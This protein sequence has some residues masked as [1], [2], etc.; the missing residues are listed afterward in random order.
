MPIR[1]PW[2]RRA[3]A[4]AGGWR[5]AILGATALL[6][7]SHVAHAGTTGKVAGLVDDRQKRPVVAATVA[8]VNQPFGAFTT[9]QGEYSILNVPPGTYELKFSRVGFKALV[10][11]N[12]VVSADNTTRIDATLDEAAITAETVVVTAERPPVDINLTSS[13]ASLRSEDIATLP[14][15]E[16]Q[17]VVNL[18]AGVVDGHFRGGRLGEVQYQVDGVSVNNAYDN[19]SS[20]RVDRS[21]LQEVQVISGTFDAEYGQA[22]SGVVNA[23]LKTGG[24]KLAWESEV[25]LGDHYFPGRESARLT[26]NTFD[27]LAITSFTFTLSGPTGLPKTVFLA[28]A[29]YFTWDDYI[30]AERR[31]LITPVYDD[32][33]KRFVPIPGDR[34]QRVLGWADEWSGALKITNSS[35]TNAKLSYQ[36]L[37]NDSDGQRTN[38][39]YRYLPDGMS[40]QHTASIAHGL[41]WTQ[42]LGKS[43][44]LSASVRQNYRKYQDF[45]YEDAWDPRYD[46][47]MPP[48]EPVSDPGYYWW[49]VDF[50]RFE[51]ITN[52]YLVKA[53]L[54]SQLSQVQQLKAGA[55]LQWPEVTFGV[56]THLVYTGLSVE[57]HDDEPLNGYPAVQ[58][59][60]PLSGAAF[61][62]DQIEWRDLTLR[63]GARLDYFDARASLPSDPAN[64]ANAIASAPQSVPQPTTPKLTLSPR[65]GVAFPV[66]DRSGMHFAYGH[67]YQYPPLGDIFANADYSILSRL[68][69]GTAAFNTVMGN[70]DVKPEMSVQYEFGYKQSLTDDFGVEFTVY[71]KDIRDLLGVEFISTYNDAE[72]SRLS[73][74][75]FGTV[76]GIIVALDHRALGPVSLALDYTWQ[77]AQG[78]S[79]D[80]NET[81]NRAAAGEDPRPRVVPFN[82]DQRHTLNMTLA[83]ESPGRYSASMVLRAASGQPFTPVTE[84]GGFGYGLEANS[85][86]KPLC[87]VVDVRGERSFAW[88]GRR[89]GVFG[90]IFNLFDSRY[91]NGFVFD[92]TGSPFYS[93]FPGPQEVTLNDPTRFFAPRRIE[94]GVSLASKR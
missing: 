91:F 81:A 38:Y 69:A 65:L 13:M 31:Y 87:A 86:R 17:D 12:V 25:Y 36:A 60:Y 80:P 58:Q 22:M 10:V 92:S 44:F 56:P 62:Q 47:A 14:V 66:T 1:E 93:R 48:G 7:G 94:L 29:R 72:Y 18:Q 40:R 27:P 71:Y 75:D 4:L 90:R 41:D 83:L 19:T 64:P 32:S 84:A 59:Y 11:Q 57:R 50:T 53:A 52:T 26:E 49:G 23:V 9:P 63:V 35:I 61:C 54:T 43:T 2:P 15:Q 70:P 34:S 20:L 3:R 89:V 67:F 74:A 5:R 88:Q 8:I 51:Q 37:F 28:N 85:G 68:Q 77:H 39:Y 33:L 16:L 46:A 78:N 73:N 21:L 6:C 30:Q 82:W 79:S 24:E 45:A 42:T 76:K 55:E